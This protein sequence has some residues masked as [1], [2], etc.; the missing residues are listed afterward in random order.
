MNKEIKEW[1]ETHK[2][3]LAVGGVVAVI[4]LGCFFFFRP[5]PTEKE[6][7]FSTTSSTNTSEEKKTEKVTKMYVDVKGAVK[8]AGMYE[9]TEEMRVQDVLDQAGGFAENADKNRVNLSQKLE[10]QMVIYVP[11]IDEK[12]EET[13]QTQNVTAKESEG[14]KK[15][16][17]NTAD[18]SELQKITG[19]GAKKAETILED[20]K[21]N[22]S[23]AS[24]EDL[25]RVKGIGAK[26]VEKI[27]DQICVK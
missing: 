25:A 23:F 9:I 20:R 27:K 10:D 21:A 13:L 11:L 14:E 16:N 7:S 4:A 2:I 24:V 3:W 22:G 18:V 6:I 12:V 1:L 8:K 5:Q 26:T 17:I 15:I 19:I